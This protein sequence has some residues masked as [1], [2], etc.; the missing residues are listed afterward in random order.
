MKWRQRTWVWHPKIKIF[1]N[2]GVAQSRTDNF[3][4]YLGT[5]SNSWGVKS[6]NLSICQKPSNLLSPHACIL[7]SLQKNDMMRL[8][9]EAEHIS[10][11]WRYRVPTTLW[12][13]IFIWT[14]KTIIQK[15]WSEVWWEAKSLEATSFHFKAT[16]VE[17][18][19]D[20]SL[21]LN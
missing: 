21:F 6:F 5:A 3:Q 19:D 2:L 9:F 17:S 8:W 20:L 4:H 16:Q 13:S 15:Y 12:C 10:T 7:N 11:E 18:Y 1:M 14:E